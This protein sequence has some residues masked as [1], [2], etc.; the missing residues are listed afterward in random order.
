MIR[1]HKA[2][3]IGLALA[4]IVRPQ[5]L[6]GDDNPAGKVR[7]RI[8]DYERARRALVVYTKN[9]AQQARD[10]IRET[11]CF[12]VIEQERSLN[13]FRCRWDGND[14][15]KL[16]RMLEELASSPAVQL[17]EPDPRVSGSQR[18]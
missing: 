1:L 11:K 16:G 10:V 6:L 17:I 8:Q 5:S 4:V 3:F 14:R 13:A 2:L 18:P 15:H 12:H 7:G 9:H